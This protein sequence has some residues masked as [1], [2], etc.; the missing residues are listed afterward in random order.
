MEMAWISSVL[1]I[2][3]IIL[4]IWEILISFTLGLNPHPPERL[5]LNWILTIYKKLPPLLEQDVLSDRIILVHPH[6]T[7]TPR[8]LAK[9]VTL[10]RLIIISISIFLI[11]W[12]LIQISPLIKRIPMIMG[13]QKFNKVIFLDKIIAQKIMKLI[14]QLPSKFN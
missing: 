11:K 5:L 1:V 9:T 14:H 12:M 6:L 3:Q 4:G 7:W 8:I 10:I 2:I 13:L